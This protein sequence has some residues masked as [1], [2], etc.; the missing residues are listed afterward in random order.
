MRLMGSRYY[1]TMAAPRPSATAK[2]IPSP[3]SRI[4]IAGQF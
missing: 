3:E 4:K 2:S 1:K